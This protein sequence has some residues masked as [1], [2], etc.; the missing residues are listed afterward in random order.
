M[1]ALKKST[2]DISSPSH[3]FLNVVT[4]ISFL[5]GSSILYTVDGVTPEREASWFGRMRFSL[6]NS[7]MRSTM[8]VLI[9]IAIHPL[10]ILPQISGKYVRRF[11]TS[12]Q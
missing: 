5:C 9:L 3:S 1:S 4:D 8:A 7:R 10:S 11:V 6:H 2:R 12:P